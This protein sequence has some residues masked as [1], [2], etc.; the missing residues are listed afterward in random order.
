MPL[1]PRT[2]AAY[3]SGNSTRHHRGRLADAGN[4]NRRCV[5]NVIIDGIK[6]DF[7]QVNFLRPS[8]IAAIEVYPHRFS[9]PDRF[10]Q[11]NE[12]GVVVVWTKWALG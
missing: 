11:N 10:V 6:A 1:A 5:A 2:L 8:D 4:G 12:C 3:R 9:V 7:Q